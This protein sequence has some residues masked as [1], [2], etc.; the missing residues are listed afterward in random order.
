QTNKSRPYVESLALF[1][2]V[3]CVSE[4]ARSDLHHFWKKY[5]CDPS[6]TCVELWPGEFE[7]AVQRETEDGRSDIVLYVSSFHGRKN[8]L[9]LLRAVENLWSDGLDFELHLIGRSVGAPFNK[10]V[11]QILKLQMRRLRLRWLRHV[12]DRELLRAYRQCRF[13]V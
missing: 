4:E 5:G 1:D 8:H 10:I 7:G 9:T 13:T 6:A 3:I 2:L 12:S 11:R